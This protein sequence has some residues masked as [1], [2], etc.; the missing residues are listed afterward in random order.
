[1]AVT[2][3]VPPRAR[4]RDA[5]ATR[6]ALLDAARSLMGEHGV[7]GTSTRD[8]AARAG[9]NQ[10]LVYRYF[11]S[12]DNLVA[13]AA[14]GGPSDH[15]LE[16][17]RTTDLADLPRV[18]LCN[19]VDGTADAERRDRMSVLVSGANDRTVR[20]VLRTRI[21]EVFGDVLGGRLEGP[22]AALRAEL[23]AALLAGVGMLREKV[24]TRALAEADREVV[25]DWV[26]RLAAVLFAPDGS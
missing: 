14:G 15:T 2:E 25:G 5:T 10:A 8:V 22:D 16:L 4:K 3:E 6:R 11:G 21:E 26:E 9:V 20:E 1:M 24:G 12:K 18:L 13:E 7:E 17:M 19:T 23:M